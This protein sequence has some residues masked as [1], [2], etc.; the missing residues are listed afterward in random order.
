MS[1]KKHPA[2]ASLSGSLGGAPQTAREVVIG[3]AGHIDHG[4]TALVRAL[5]GI[6]TDRLPDE[7]RRGITIDLGF[8]SMA[9][10]M[11]DS[12]PL[13]LSF[14]DVPGH[15]LFIRNMLA[16]ATGVDLVMLV[17]SAEEGVKPQTEEHLAICSLLGITRGLTVVTKADAVSPERL[18]QVCVEVAEYLQGSFLEGSA[19]LPASA[20]AGTGLTAVREHL[21]ALAAQVPAHDAGGLPR[22]PLDR[23]FVMRGFGTIVTGTLQAGTVQ[24]EDTLTIEPGQRKVRVRGVQMHGTHYSS[25][26]GGSRVAL[27]LAGVEVADVRRGDTLVAPSTFKAVDTVDAELTLLPESAPLKH[28][29]RIRV[30]AFT[31]DTLATVSL[32]G[33]TQVAGG[34]KMLARLRLAKPV[35][36]LPGDRFIVRQCSPA[37]TMGGGRVL[38]ATPLPKLKRAATTAWLESIRH[39]SP[40][41][42]IAARVR[43]RGTAG[44]STAALVAETGMSPQQIE[45]ALAALVDAHEIMLAGED[46]WLECRTCNEATA[47]LLSAITAAGGGGRKR[48]ELPGQVG[49]NETV[50][51]AILERLV[52]QRKVMLQGDLVRV[53]GAGPQLSPQEQHWLKSVEDS[54]AKAGLAPPLLR[55]VMATTRLSEPELRRS[56]TVLLREG[57]LVKLGTEDL[58]IH[59]R[60]LDA[61][62]GQVRSLR[63]QTLDVAQFKQLTGLSRKYAVP[64]LEHLD[65]AHLTRRQGDLRHVL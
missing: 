42:Q 7:K 43:R 60:A 17:I 55:D 25:A 59:Q 44:T 14:V 63:G 45:S 56:I 16:G 48:S 31:S 52:A 15:H 41:E 5:T 24:Q 10:E 28:R 23:A 51:A 18:Q 19:I 54:F 34:E 27:N 13:R 6:D 53:A 9:A 3:T 37:R 32:Y 36:L 35:V 40:A 49:L 65:R 20:L 2:R 64:L 39:A 21:T 57:T 1:G 11:P 8:A 58:Y 33:V 46:R 26:R 47:S 4:K 38:D 12:E 62:Y 61:L 30:H 50:F 29:A 22:L